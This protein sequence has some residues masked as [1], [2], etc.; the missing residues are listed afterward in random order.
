MEKHSMKNTSN[1]PT[2]G[3]RQNPAYLGVI[4]AISTA[5]F[6]YYVWW[7]LTYTLN[8]NA[9]F[10]SW[11]LLLAETFGVLSYMLFAWMTQ[12]ISSNRRYKPPRAGLTVD[13][14]IPTFNES[15]E[16]LEATMVGCR[17]IK[18][19]HKTYILDDGKRAEVRQLALLLGCTYLNRPT[20]EH[21]KAGNINHA[22]AK[23]AGEFIVVLDADMVPQP[24]FLDRTLG[25][26]EDE[27]LAFIQMPQE[28]YNQDSIQHDQEEKHWH[29]QSLFFRVI[30]PGK[31]YSNSVFWCGSPSIVRRKA[32]LE[33]GGVATDTITEDIH[34]SVRLHSHGW[35]SFFLDEVLAYGIAPQTIKSFLVQRLR[36]A[37]GTM[38]LYRSSESPIWTKGLTIQQ[39]LSYLSSFLA[40]FEAFQKFILIM[41]PVFIIMFNVF[42][43]QVNMRTF[44]VRWVP[45]FILTILAN[46]AGGRG[47][48]R[49]FQTEK[50]NILKMAVFI[51]STLT[52]FHT[53]DLKFKVTPKSVDNS[54]YKE[55]RRTLRFYMVILGMITGAII[56]GLYNTIFKPRTSLQIEVYLI[57]IF[58]AI[59]NALLI[60]IGIYEVLK[61][62]HERKQYRFTVDLEGEIHRD[63]YAGEIMKVRV[64]NLSITGASLAVEDRFL[65]ESNKL[66][67]HI[68]TETGRSII[69]SINKIHRQV[70]DRDG[71]IRIGVSFAAKNDV[72][73]ERLFEYLFVELPAMLPVP[74]RD[75]AGLH[76]LAIFQNLLRQRLDGI[77]SEQLLEDTIQ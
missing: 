73:R 52:L 57:A 14:L 34:T 70:K 33:V 31:N 13:I 77:S 22:L 54:V 69:L 75:K 47:Y 29:E 27:N 26:F 42:P 9:L 74:T 8:P 58:W 37:Q 24:N 10:V 36:W 12:D 3:K 7:R 1:P 32:L 65:A 76:D 19:P 38:Q 53:K 35:S 63:G 46:Q 66:L 20:N 43:M 50:Y 28:F 51:Q 4:S 56:Y 71:C 25:Y 49:Y 64:E 11:V 68:H 41:M 48:F 61:K 15:L 40:Y 67:L 17:K 39:R 55:E 5:Y 16:I 6:L 44:L 59:Y 18:Y 23:T 72:Y 45:Y 62:S 21:A 30:Q 60:F 2:D